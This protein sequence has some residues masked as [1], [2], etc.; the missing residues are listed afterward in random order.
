MRPQPQ[1][2]WLHLVGFCIAT[3]LVT[4]CA[5]DLDQMSEEKAVEAT[6][7]SQR[8]AVWRFGTKQFGCWYKASGNTKQFTNDRLEVYANSSLLTE[9]GPLS[10]GKIARRSLLWAIPQGVLSVAFNLWDAAECLGAGASAIGAL[11][12]GGLSATL[13]AALVVPCATAGAG[14]YWGVEAQ[15]M[16]KPRVS[17]L[18]TTP[19]TTRNTGSLA[20]AS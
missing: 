19:L 14:I 18:P 16:Y 8:I 2:G 20:Q 10:A 11:F 3:T 13:A 12:T 7:G 17:Q 9:S 5:G 1:F 4:A 15:K 6:S